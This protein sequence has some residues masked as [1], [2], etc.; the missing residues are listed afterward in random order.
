MRSKRAKKK[1]TRVKS[2]RKKTNAYTIY[3]L[4]SAICAGIS[5][6]GQVASLST[7]L[8]GSTGS[9]RTV[10]RM[11][12]RIVLHFFEQKANSR[13]RLPD[14]DLRLTVKF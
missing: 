6:L 11:E 13:T 4:L 5:P 3:Y 8:C 12:L 14:P 10:K 9:P 7:R 2:A 1:T